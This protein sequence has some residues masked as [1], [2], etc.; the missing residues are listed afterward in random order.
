MEMAM[1]AIE[2]NVTT[3]NELFREVFFTIRAMEE[4]MQNVKMSYA[5][6]LQAALD[7]EIPPDVDFFTSLPVPSRNQ[8]GIYAIILEDSNGTPCLYI[9]S[10]TATNGGVQGRLRTYTNAQTHVEKH[11]EVWAPTASKPNHAGMPRL[12]EK[13][14]KNGFRIVHAGM[15]A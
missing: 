5:P 14:F 8:W 9:G 10:G 1:F 13:A 6:G 11:G 3:T 15:L 7:G 2:Q 4:I 12:V